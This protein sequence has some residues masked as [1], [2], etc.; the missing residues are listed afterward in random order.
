M[1]VYF[2]LGF[3]FINMADEEGG[4]GQFDHSLIRIS[5]DVVVLNQEIDVERPESPIT[6]T[7]H[8]ENEQV[9]QA[10]TANTHLP[11]EEMQ[12]DDDSSSEGNF[13]ELP[14]D[15]L[16]GV[17]EVEHLDGASSSRTRGEGRVQ[18]QFYLPPSSNTRDRSP[19]HPSETEHAIGRGSVRVR[20]SRISCA[21]VQIP[22]SVRKRIEV[23]EPSST[24]SSS[25]I[26]LTQMKQLIVQ[27]I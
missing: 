11:D 22:R 25:Y 17:D 2:I 6:T 1:T 8:P 12:A 9:T 24:S 23:A 3:L 4:M 21:P 13:F 5:S 20:H 16:D 7:Q 14:D 10:P 26:P 18:N 15:V 19:S 27:Y